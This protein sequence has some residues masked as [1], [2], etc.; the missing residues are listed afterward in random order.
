MIAITLYRGEEA[1]FRT[2]NDET[3]AKA[4][5]RL[6]LKEHGRE[7]RAGTDTWTLTLVGECID[8]T[9][10]KLHHVD[11]TINLS[12]GGSIVGPSAAV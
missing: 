2:V 5:L 11:Q 1:V 4:H 8:P 9:T 12:A 3:L 6:F 7:L 10:G